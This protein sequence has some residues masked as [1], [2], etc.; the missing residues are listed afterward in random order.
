MFPTCVSWT[1]VRIPLLTL[2]AIFQFPFCALGLVLVPIYIKLKTVKT[3]LV[4]KLCRV[5]WVGGFFFIGGLT[6]FLV[7]ISWAGIQFEW[8]SAQA[9]TP[10]IIGI[11]GVTIAIIW[12]IYGAQEPFLR[13][14]LFCSVSA[15]AT[16]ACALFQ[17]FIVCLSCPKPALDAF[18][19]P[20]PRLQLFCALYYIP[21]YFTAIRFKPP[22]QSGLDIFPVTCFLLPGSI[23]ISLMTTRL[24]RYRWAIWSGWVVTALGC[25]LLVLLDVDTKTPV[26]AV[27]LAI[28][29]IGHGMLLTS[30]NIGIQAVSRVEDAGRAAAM[31]AFMRTLGMSIGVAVGGTVFQ[32]VMIN[33]LDTLGMP[34]SI[35]HNSEAYVRTLAAMDPKNPERVAA[36]QACERTPPPVKSFSVPRAD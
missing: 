36:V 10:M 15:L 31:Y 28:F 27:I 13:P 14:S 29:G 24:G 6:S 3:S 11:V 18:A 16:Y 20:K 1:E 35:A 21:F 7:G 30:V 2:N 5:D 4:S 12:E 22:T 19:D 33:K 23:I 32:N 9:V 8:K 34:H 26:W 25:G 17:G